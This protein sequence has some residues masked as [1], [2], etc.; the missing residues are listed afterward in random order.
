MDP[1]VV[2]VGDEEVKS[3]NIT[4]TIRSESEPNKPKNVKMTVQELNE[5]GR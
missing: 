1:Y 2:V 4:V 5:K 3:G